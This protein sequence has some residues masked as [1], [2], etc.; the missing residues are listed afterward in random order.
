MEIC[1]ISSATGRKKTVKQMKKEAEK[2]HLSLA[3]NFKSMCRFCPASD[4]GANDFLSVGYNPI[5]FFVCSIPINRR[6][7]H[8][9]LRS[10]KMTMEK[11]INRTYE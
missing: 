6:R 11:R 10:A 5:A 7:T 1:Q 4:A 9:K 8:A 2:W 3:S